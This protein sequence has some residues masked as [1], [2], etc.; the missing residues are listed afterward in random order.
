MGWLVGYPLEEEDDKRSKV[1]SMQTKYVANA[2][3]T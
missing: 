1:L 3:H 2:S